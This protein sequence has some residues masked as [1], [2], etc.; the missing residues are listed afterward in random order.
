MGEALLGE[1]DSYPSTRQ[2]VETILQDWPDHQKYLSKSFKDRPD[3]V[4]DLAERT[5][6]IVMRL[7]DNDL[8]GSIKGYRWMCEMLFEEELYFRRSGSYRH[9][10]FA[11][12]N[13]A[14]YQNREQ[15]GA[16][17]DG[18]LASEVL[19]IQHART[20]DF[21]VNT[22][23]PA[24]PDNYSHLEIGPGHGLLLY[25]AAADPRCARL[26]GWDISPASLDLTAHALKTLG[27]DKPVQLQ[28]QNVMKPPQ[29]EQRFDSIVISEVLEH[30]EDPV[31]ALRNLSAVLSDAGRIY[32][33]VPVNAPAIDH[34][35]LLRSPEETMALLSDTGLEAVDTLF[36]PAAGYTLERARKMKLSVSCAIAARRV[37]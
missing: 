5:A 1:L 16:Y 36:A 19:W 25:F 23:L 4:R 7:V 31:A 30:L 26:T 22:F 18:L 35:Y 9:S 32:I 34:I 37:R 24:N 33:N 27:V 2:L 13:D 3:S 8:S 17:M 12:V 28:A 21:Y 20:M 14:V 10:S 29:T 15:M 6:A 11:E